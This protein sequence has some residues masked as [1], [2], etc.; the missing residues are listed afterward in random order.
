[1]ELNGSETEININASTKEP[2]NVPFPVDVLNTCLNQWSLYYV[3]M[4]NYFDSIFVV[5]L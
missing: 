3:F 1:M 4:I 2:I 5:Q